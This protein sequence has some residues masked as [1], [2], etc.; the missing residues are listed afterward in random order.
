MI[1]WNDDDEDDQLSRQEP[2]RKSSGK[3]R[4]KERFTA[5]LDLDEKEWERFF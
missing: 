4:Q 2:M 1:R 3:T 5:P